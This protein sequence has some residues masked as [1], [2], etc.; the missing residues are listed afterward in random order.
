MA[1][2]EPERVLQLVQPLA[3]RLV[4]AVGQPAPSLQ[5]HGGTQETVPV[6]PVTRAA[7]GAA[8]AK[9]A[10]VVAIELVAVLRRLQPFP[11][12]RGRLRLEPGLDHL[13]LRED[14]A[15]IGN[16]VLDDPHVRQRIDSR[17]RIRFLDESCAGQPVRAVHV[18]GA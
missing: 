4:A 11:V 8:E 14:M 9:D 6:P 17:R 1:P 10:L 12:R 3:S 15:E 13:V 7:G 5:K 18:H 2:I 16:E